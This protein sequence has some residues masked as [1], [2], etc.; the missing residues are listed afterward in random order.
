ARSSTTSEDHPVVSPTAFLDNGV[1]DLD[2]YV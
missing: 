2:E 1:T